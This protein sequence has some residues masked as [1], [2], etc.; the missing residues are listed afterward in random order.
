MQSYEKVPLPKRCDTVVAARSVSYSRDYLDYLEWFIPKEMVANRRGRW[1]VGVMAFKSEQDLANIK[2]NRS[3]EENGLDDKMLDSDFGTKTYKLHAFISGCYFLN[4][5]DSWVSDGMSI[6]SVTEKNSGCT[7]SHLT[8]F[9]T[10]FFPMAN[11][12]DFKFVF[13]AASFQDNL[14][15][16]LLLIFTIGTYLAVMIWA[17]VRDKKDERLIR[18]PA[19]RDN[20]PEDNY[21]YELIVETGPMANHGTTSKVEFILKGSDESTEVRTLNDPGRKLFGAGAR[22]AFLM[23]TQFPLGELVSLRIW[24]DSTGLADA[25]SWYLLG[26]S[27]LDLQT[28]EKTRFIADQWLALDR[29]PF[30]VRTYGFYGTAKRVLLYQRESSTVRVN[31]HAG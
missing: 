29:H 1:F 14:T 27:V 19:M 8:S 15:I 28:G 2:A 21:F 10:G 5:R 18:S 6:D 16:N 22:D 30:E 11:S 3:C 17:I 4:Q 25:G 13:A 20:H 26:V 9:A 24:Q 31:F 12:L 23:S 7:T